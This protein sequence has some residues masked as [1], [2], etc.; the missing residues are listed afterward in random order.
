MRGSFRT[1]VIEL[2]EEKRG[3][4]WK[5]GMLGGPLVK[6]LQELSGEEFK[7]H[8]TAGAMLVV[9]R[10]QNTEA[11]I[12]HKLR[13]ITEGNYIIPEHAEHKVVKPY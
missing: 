4:V 11:E 13:A 1:V 7:W 3:Q 10:G 9:P 6:L 8:V 5:A 12:V 2:P